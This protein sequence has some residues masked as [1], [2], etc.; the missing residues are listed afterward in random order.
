M[1]KGMPFIGTRG[2]APKMNIERSADEAGQTWRIS[3]RRYEAEVRTGARPRVR[4]FRDGK[5]LMRLPL[6]SGLGTV[7]VAEQLGEAA[8]E[9]AEESGSGLDLELTARSSLW[10]GRHF[11]WAFTDDEV[12]YWHSAAGEGRPGRCW[13]FSNGPARGRWAL[14][15][16]QRPVDTA[17]ID[18]P[19]VFS[20]G[21]NLADEFERPICISQSLGILPEEEY[22][23]QL[24]LPDRLAEIFAP[25]MLS[26][27]FGSGRRWAGVSLGTEPGAYR[28]NSFEYTGSDTSGGGFFVNY[29]GYHN[30]GGLFSSPV[31]AL[32]F[33]TDPHEVFACG[34]EWLSA[35]GYAT[36]R[37]FDPVDWHRL[38]VFCGWGEQTTVAQDTGGRA[39]DESTQANYESWIR[40]VDRRR[41]PVGTVVIDDK[42]QAA[43]GTFEIDTDK[44]PDMAGFVRSQHEAGRHVLLWIPVYHCEGLPENLCV[45][46]GGAAIAADVSHPEYEAFLRDRIRCLVDEVGVDGFKVD[47]VRGVAREAGV[48]THAPLHG[49]EWLHRFQ[50]VLYEETHRWRPDALIEAHAALP[51]FRNCSDVFRLNDLAGGARNIV[52]AMK[53]RARLARIAGWPT[54]DCDNSGPTLEEWWAGMQAQ[55]HYGVPSLYRLTR[56]TLTG[57]VIPDALWDRLREI[58]ERY[59][60]GES[61]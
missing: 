28:F 19:R 5:L 15:R 46:H 36:P 18:A 61:R 43:Y 23:K 50:T 47:W 33:G 42:W 12:R 16:G 26:L 32:H 27:C 54:A 49:I 60:A 21:A 8:I 57:E 6:V 22:V 38:P 31:A 9:R 20:F 56:L 37:R 3:G 48:A 59:V 52:A 51:L 10:A 25:P 7:E 58:W 30:P 55:P 14:R 24:A 13:F 53:E 29:L 41:L 4:V 39:A 45:R 40:T 44:W 35:A 17:I 11:F 2:E 1:P 34:A